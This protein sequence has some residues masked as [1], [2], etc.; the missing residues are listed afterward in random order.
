MLVVQSLKQWKQL[1]LHT[2]I[3]IISN[4]Q[5]TNASVYTVQC[6]PLYSILL[7]IGR[8]HVDYFGLGVESAYLKIDI[9]YFEWI[10][11]PEIITSGMMANKVRQ[12]GIEVHLSGTDSLEKHR[13]WAKILRTIERNGMVRF[14]S[15]YNPWWSGEFMKFPLNGSFGHEI[16]WYNRKLLNTI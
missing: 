4:N 11:L 6:F 9:E 8:T 15:K 16:A 7:A 14:D 10:A 2:S 3:N 13:G 1:M 12:L 5:N